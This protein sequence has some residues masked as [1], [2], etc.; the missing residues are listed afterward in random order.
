[1]ANERFDK[2]VELADRLGRQ[3]MVLDSALCCGYPGVHKDREE[4]RA[5]YE[6]R[7]AALLEEAGRLGH[8]EGGA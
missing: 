2:L 3:R 4:A 5:E 1:M 8:V 6:K 7:K